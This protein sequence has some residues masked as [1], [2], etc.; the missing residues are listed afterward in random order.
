MVKV[1]GMCLLRLFLELNLTGL[2]SLLQIFFLIKRL[3]SQNG[4]LVFETPSVSFLLIIINFL[5]ESKILED[6]EQSECFLDLHPLFLF[7]ET[8]INHQSFIDDELEFPRVNLLVRPTDELKHLRH[9]LVSVLLLRFGL[10]SKLS[11]VFDQETMESRPFE[12]PHVGLELPIDDAH[13]LHQVENCVCDVKVEVGL[14]TLLVNE[15]LLEF[16]ESI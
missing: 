5:E 12:E 6:L 3:F 7:F 11:L 16:I 10:S 15:V 13:R 9:E 8:C 1:E 14:L 4:I 2:C